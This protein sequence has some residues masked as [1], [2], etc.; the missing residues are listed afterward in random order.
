MMNSWVVWA[1]LNSIAERKV[2]RAFAFSN[3]VILCSWINL[4]RLVKVAKTPMEKL[5]LF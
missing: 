4:S 5:Y 2:Y 1:F 3:N